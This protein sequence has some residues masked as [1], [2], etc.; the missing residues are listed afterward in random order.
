M[1]ASLGHCST[2]ITSNETQWIYFNIN[3]VSVNDKNSSYFAYFFYKHP[4]VF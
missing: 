4:N 1:Y 3:S 2:V